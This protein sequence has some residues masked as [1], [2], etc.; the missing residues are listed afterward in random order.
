M[1]VPAQTAATA[2]QAY[3]MVRMSVAAETCDL[4]EPD[5]CRLFRRKRRI[6]SKNRNAWLGRKGS[7]HRMVDPPVLRDPSSNN[8]AQN[9][10]AFEPER[11]VAVVTGT[12]ATGLRILPRRL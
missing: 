8:L 4:Q 5:V 2:T 10:L 11:S 6:F 9:G 7:N 12:A 3:F 1:Q